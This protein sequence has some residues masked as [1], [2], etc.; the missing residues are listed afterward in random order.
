MRHLPAFAA[1]IHALNSVRHN[2]VVAARVSWPWYA[3]LV[4]VLVAATGFLQSQRTGDPATDLTTELAVQVAVGAIA[5]FA[6]SS[7]AVNWHRYILL[8]EVPVRISSLLRS[9]DKVWRYFGNMLLLMLILAAG[10]ALIMLPLSIIAGLAG[11]GEAMA[12]VIVLIALPFIGIGFLRLGLK[13]PAIALDRR[14]F[15]LIS[16]W[17]VT[18]GNDLPIAGVFVL[19]LL[20]GMAVAL[21]A[22]LIVALLS[23]GNAYLGFVASF[24]LEIAVNWFLTLLGITLLTSLYGFFVEGR[25]F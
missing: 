2:L 24:I 4:A 3:I 1:I 10:A 5:L 8:D 14:D 22:T 23:L 21:P 17:Q 15:S 12:I 9:D 18:K 11:A 16:S 6:C 25:D 7:V 13:L 19:N 20:I